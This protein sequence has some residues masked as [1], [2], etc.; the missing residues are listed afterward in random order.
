MKEKAI[1]ELP[2]DQAIPFLGI[3]PDKTK[4]QKDICTHM[5]IAALCIV[6]KT[7]KSK[8]SSTD[9]WIKTCCMCVCVEWNR[10]VWTTTQP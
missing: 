6:A 7:W 9:E 2:Y 8:C 3:Y 5:F 4:I 1:R 10:H